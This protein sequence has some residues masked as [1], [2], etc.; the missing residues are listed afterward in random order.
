MFL[1]LMFPSL[2]A[3]HYVGLGCNV[4]LCVQKIPDNSIV[5]GEE[6]SNLMKL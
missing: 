4:V 1:T 2:Q 5:D 6:V 3:S